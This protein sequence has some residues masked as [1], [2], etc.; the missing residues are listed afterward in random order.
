MRGGLVAFVIATALANAASASPTKSECVDANTRGQQL[1]KSGKLL[2]AREALQICADASCPRIVRADCQS[3][4]D[5]IAHATPSIVV[6]TTDVTLDGKPFSGTPNAPYEVDPGE[7]HVLF[8]EPGHPAVERV[9][10]LDEGERP[11]RV[12]VTYPKPVPPPAGSKTFLTVGF[13]LGGAG[14]AGLGLGIALGIASFGAWGAV[15]GECAS[16]ITCDYA[17]ATADRN[18]ATDFATGAD[19]A[20]I[21]G[22]LLAAAGITFVV[23]GAQVHPVVQEKLL[24]LS[25]VKAF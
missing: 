15:K 5:E 25:L 8:H 18:T 10:T 17:K 19:V 4:I 24:G 12:T 22:G 6:E 9:V 7:H 23:L 11:R 20:F 2:E 21:A 1:R 3:R 16:A 13:A 14:I